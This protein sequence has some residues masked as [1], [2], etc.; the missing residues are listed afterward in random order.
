[1]LFCLHRSRTLGCLL[2]AVVAWAGPGCSSEPATDDERPTIAFYHWRTGLSL[3]PSERRWLDS[4]AVSRLYVKAFDVDWSS[5]RLMP[6]PQALLVI[7]SASL[8]DD[9]ALVPVVFITNRT[10]ER[11]GG[12]VDTL[13][14]RVAAKV[15]ERLQGYPFDELQ[16]DC[17]WTLGTRAAY[18]RFL[19]ALRQ[20]LPPATTLSATI[21]LHQLRYADKTG[22]PPVDRGVLMYYNMGQVEDWHESNSILNLQKAAPYLQAPGYSLPLDL[23]LPLFRWGV[24]FRH[25]RLIKLINN[26]EASALADSSR[27]TPLGPARYRVRESTYLAG[28]YLY[29]DDE[30][31]LEG[32]D[33]T[34]LLTAAE[35]WRYYAGA[36]TRR[37]IFYHLDSV[38][39]KSFTYAT[40][41]TTADR[42]VPA[43]DGPP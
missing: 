9:I 6:V 23:A 15:T 31:R 19:A 5:E 10:L 41:R 3:G 18:F 22:V 39:L 37:V 30:I 13:A 17:D 14:A 12:Q 34:A 36:P 40:L 7:D 33:S 38:V 32:V 2:L 4:L 43:G 21:R 25:G 42:L 26:L 29:R 11:A 16:I 20:Q 1:M 27:F 28:Y 8:P 35:Q 24:L